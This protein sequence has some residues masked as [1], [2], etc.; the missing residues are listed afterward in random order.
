[1]IKIT[2]KSKISKKE[3][4]KSYTVRQILDFCGEDALIEDIIKCDCTQIQEF[5]YTPCNC[6]EEWFDYILIIG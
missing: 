3:I 1:M 5:G 4:V 2:I 6:D